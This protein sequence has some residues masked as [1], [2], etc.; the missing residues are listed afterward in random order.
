MC[1]TA[2]AWLYEHFGRASTNSSSSTSGDSKTTTQS[3]PSEA[4]SLA[5]ARR[6]DVDKISQR[7][8]ELSDKLDRL[9]QRVAAIPKPEPGPDLT[10]LQNQ[11]ATLLK[12]DETFAV[13]PSRL[14]ALDERINGLDKSV[15]ELRR[16]V[17][18]LADTLKKTNAPPTTP[19]PVAPTVGGLIQ[20]SAEMARLTDPELA[21]GI[22][23]FQKGR[24]AEARDVFNGLQKSKGDDCASGTIPRWRTAWRRI[25]GR[26]RPNA[27]SRR[28][29]SASSGHSR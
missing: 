26:A 13:L 19:L 7:L 24:Y 6:E 3:P 20:P 21:R 1:G 18:T 28:G 4:A 12:D 9:R 2:G 8:D 16:E 25:S 29:L 22:D 15:R 10:D 5:S 17:E 27:S 14:S 11:I 23:L